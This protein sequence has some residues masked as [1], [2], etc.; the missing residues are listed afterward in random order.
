MP[1]S[2]LITSMKS[3]RCGQGLG[4]PT[5]SWPKRAAKTPPDGRCEQA[6]MSS[7][8]WWETGRNGVPQG[9]S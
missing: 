9:T 2:E 3:V 6:P 5:D 1:S 8:G 4:Q 7:N